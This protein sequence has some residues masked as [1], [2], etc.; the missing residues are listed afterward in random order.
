MSGLSPL[1]E[2]D[3]LM[4]KLTEARDKCKVDQPLVRIE[5]PNGRVYAIKDIVVTGRDVVIEVLYV[6]LA[7]RG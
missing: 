4:E 1:I 2:F 7:A 3:D 6:E 5:S